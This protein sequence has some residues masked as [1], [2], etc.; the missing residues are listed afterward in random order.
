MDFAGLNDD[1]VSECTH[2]YGAVVA[3]DDAMRIMINETK[4]VCVSHM[5]GSGTG[6]NTGI[7]D[8]CDI[9]MTNKTLDECSIGERENSCVGAMVALNGI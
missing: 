5:G 9:C 3:D 4:T 1:V 7:G 2:A 8:R 6:M